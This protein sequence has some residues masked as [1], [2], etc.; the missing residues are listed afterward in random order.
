MNDIVNHP[1]HYNA[2][3][4]EVIDIIE[5]VVMSMD[6]TPFQGYCLGNAIKYLGR[7]RHKGGIEDIE[8]AKWYI[9]KLIDNL[10]K[11]EVKI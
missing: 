3:R 5:S 4:Y 6:L 2:G 11:K 1:T 8:K 9:N 7:F 10:E